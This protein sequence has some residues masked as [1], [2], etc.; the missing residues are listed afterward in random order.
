MSGSRGINFAHLRAG[1]PARTALERAFA[2]RD[3]RERALA[4][5]LLETLWGNLN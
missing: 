5:P 3:I 4:D 2:L 1:R